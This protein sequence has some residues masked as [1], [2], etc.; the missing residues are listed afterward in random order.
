MVEN[1]DVP[2]VVT[3]FDIH[4]NINPNC[5]FPFGL[6][7]FLK[8][9]IYHFSFCFTFV[10]GHAKEESTVFPFSDGDIG[11]GFAFPSEVEGVLFI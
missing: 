4:S 8:S 7:V 1:G 5:T 2:P 9:G 10:P 11:I 3:S 6:A